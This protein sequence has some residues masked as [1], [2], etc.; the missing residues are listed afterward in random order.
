MAS[1]D[2]D[3]I[4]LLRAKWQTVQDIL[5]DI[6]PSLL[7][8]KNWHVE[9][10]G[11][12]KAAFRTIF[13]WSPDTNTAREAVI[14]VRLY[15]SDRDAWTAKWDGS[16]CHPHP[17]CDRPEPAIIHLLQSIASTL[18]EEMDRIW[19]HKSLLPEEFP[20]EEGEEVETWLQKDS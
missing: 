20:L 13:T 1:M 18:D 14:K 2:P 3:N 6:A 17:I 7:E 16:R 9:L 12:N 19:Y 8:E 4:H 15:P 5:E 11:R 10:I